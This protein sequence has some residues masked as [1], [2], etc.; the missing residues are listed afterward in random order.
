MM[1]ETTIGMDDMWKPEVCLLDGF[2]H[3]ATAAT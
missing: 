3:R 2:V 1:I